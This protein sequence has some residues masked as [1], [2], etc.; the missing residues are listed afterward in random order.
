[1][2]WAPQY[3]PPPGE[4][5]RHY[6]AARH[7]AEQDQHLAGVQQFTREKQGRGQPA[8][9]CTEPAG[10][11]RGGSE[12]G[13]ASAGKEYPTRPEQDDEGPRGQEPDQAE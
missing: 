11:D 9:K 6:P 13:G 4:N 5:C 12:R 3:E 1:V 7:A 2:G 10:Q 8:G